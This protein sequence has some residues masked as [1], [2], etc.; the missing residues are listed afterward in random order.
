MAL[1]LAAAG[2]FLALGA[3]LA[4]RSEWESGGPRAGRGLGS[5]LGG[6]TALAVQAVWLEADR[7]VIERD[8]ARAVVLLRSLADLEPQMVSASQ[9][10]AQQIGWNMLPG[11]EDPA[12]RWSLVREALEIHD[13]CVRV[14]P[15]SAEARTNRARYLLF[16]V[17]GE[18]ALAVR[19][20]NQTGRT[21]ASAARADL[22]AALALDPADSD[23]AAG[24]AF[25]AQA[26]ARDAV[27]AR[28][29]DEAVSELTVALRWL[30][31]TLED[32]R[33][34]LAASGDDLVARARIAAG[35]RQTEESRTLLAE[36]LDIVRDGSQD[37]ARRDERLR[38]F[39]E[40][41]DGGD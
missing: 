6:F 24:L 16:K 5:A 19:F 30:D 12:A 27:D 4:A 40:G 36:L 26:A 20:A 28:R 2:T 37:G 41:A 15:H 18:E 25:A 14:N 34:T 17:A 35:I 1:R 7:A 39:R 23:A 29:W 22:E 10:A 11:H 9:Y 32:A 33:R 3:A 8:D 38:R 21:A 31:V 13:A